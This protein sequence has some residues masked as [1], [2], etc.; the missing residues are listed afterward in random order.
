MDHCDVFVVYCV[1]V[2]VQSSLT[3]VA[4]L[5]PQWA[6]QQS[7]VGLSSSLLVAAQGAWLRRQQSRRLTAFQ[8]EVRLLGRE[9]ACKGW[10]IGFVAVHWGLLSDVCM[11]VYSTVH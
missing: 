10:T 7:P 8:K 11:H 2:Q 3:D 5:Q 4:L 9:K 6:Q 1:A